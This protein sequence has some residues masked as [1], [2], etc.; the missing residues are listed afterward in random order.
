M[1]GVRVVELA[2]IGPCPF[3][4]M[5]LAEMGAD[6]LRADRPFRGVMD[7]LDPAADLLGRG[8]RSI[9]LDLKRPEAVAALLDL[10][11]TADVL[12]EGFR[13]GVSARR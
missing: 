10:C 3:A 4:G 12:L 11:D 9:V 8:K 5:I 13:P 7:V 1:A 6:V 2:G